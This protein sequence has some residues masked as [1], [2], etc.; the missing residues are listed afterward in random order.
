VHKQIIGRRQAAIA[1]KSDLGASYEPIEHWV[2]MLTR[3]G[4]RSAYME[5]A[6]VSSRSD[7][8]L[9]AAL[10]ADYNPYALALLTSLRIMY[11][12]GQNNTI[13]LVIR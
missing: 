6:C 10:A 4:G 9:V 2:S 12:P 8:T 5:G 13:V 1:W 11:Q 3:G 7:S